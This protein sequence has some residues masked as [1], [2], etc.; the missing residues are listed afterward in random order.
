MAAST[1]FIDDSG[2]ENRVTYTA[3]VVTHDPMDAFAESVESVREL[4]LTTRAALGVPGRVR[5]HGVDLVRRGTR[6]PGADDIPLPQH[7]LDFVF[8]EGLHALSLMPHVRLASV[9]ADVGYLNQR[10]G[11]R[12]RTERRTLAGQDPPQAKHGTKIA[13]LWH[14]LEVLDEELVIAPESGL[15]HRV[16]LDGSNNQEDLATV[17]AY[18]KTH[19]RTGL[20]EPPRLRNSRQSR[21]LQLVDLSAFSCF[22]NLQTSLGTDGSQARAGVWYRTFLKSKWLPSERLHQEYGHF[23]VDV[24]NPDA[25]TLAAW[26]ERLSQ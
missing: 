19:P 7:R 13:A 21:F 23:S 16:I 1:I 26:Q 9:W 14:L 2:D 15:S 17:I 12:T 24:T 10:A 25:L 4:C 5:W 20:L 6:A 8:Q 18:A 3:L 11:K 22:Q